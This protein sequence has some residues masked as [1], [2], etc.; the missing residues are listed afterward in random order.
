MFLGYI[1]YFR[2]LA[3]FFIITGHSIDVF[4]W[5]DI[6][7][8]RSL[9]IFLSNGSVL[10]VFIAGYLFQH[11]SGK[12]DQRKYY[13]SKIK[14][15]ITPYFIISIPAIVIFTTVLERDPIWAGF[16]DN[17][18]LEQIALF[19]LTGKHLAPLWFIPMIFIFY[20]VAPLLV[21]ADKNKAIYYCLPLFILLS[22]FISRG[23]PPQS[24]LHFFS[25]YLLGMYCSKFKSFINPLISRNIFIIFTAT[26][27]SLFSLFEFFYMEGTMTYVNFL[28]KLSMAIFFLGLFIKYNSHLNSKFISVIADTSFG[29]FFIHSYLLTSGKLLYL[30][31]NGAAPEGNLVSY[32]IV[33]VATLLICSFIITQIKRI[34]G[35]H[36]KLLVGS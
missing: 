2:A 20:I 13:K 7:I 28:Q 16:Y 19:Y 36:S 6:D 35:K 25:A 26:L 8:E 30:N 34:F 4:T 32:F 12:F 33:A 11:L 21:I 29:V 10:F 17:S 31:V 15:V 23:L 3:I 22:C 5:G 27:V 14:N 9:R 1:H 24:F 18:T